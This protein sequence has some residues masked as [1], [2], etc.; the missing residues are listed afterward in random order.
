MR[1][2]DVQLSLPLIMVAL[3]FMVIFGQGLGPA[4]P[5]ERGMRVSVQ[6][7]WRVVAAAV[8][9]AAITF[10]SFNLLARF[11]ELPKGPID[12]WSQ[13]GVTFLAALLVSTVLSY[14]VLR[15]RWAGTQL[16]C[17][18]FVAYFG[19]YTFIPQSEAMLFMAG[20]LP[21]T[22]SALL[23]A[24]GFLGALVYS[25]VLVALMGRLRAQE[26]ERES[27]RLHMPAGEWLWKVGVC[28]VVGPAVDL[29]GRAAFL[30]GAVPLAQ[31][32]LTYAVSLLVGKSLLLIA[33]M[34]PVIKMMKGGRLETAL[35]VGLLL[36]VLAGVAP[37]AMAR[38]YVPE[39]FSLGH[40]L[41]ISV[42]NFL[43]GLLV[44]Y[45]FSR[46]AAQL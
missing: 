14:L 17:A 13:L 6:Y 21:L 28:V 11:E 39:L 9:L 23:T 33:F 22:T 18:I 34:L 16:M 4:R 15:S 20:R 26:V 3:C 1:A 30:S 12:Q 40:L 7:L 31:P 29:A 36:G 38:F 44:G 10:G 2:V 8:L 46:E 35:A 42:A 27:A 5:W 25:L 45:L 32:Q 41:G 43:Y 37:L 19:L 24:H